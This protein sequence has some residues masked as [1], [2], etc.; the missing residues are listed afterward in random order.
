MIK[1][2]P[3]TCWIAIAALF[4]ALSFSCAN[5]ATPNGGPYD[6]EPPR[7][8]S[9]TPIPNQLTYKGKRV[10]ILFDE[11]IKLDNPLEN[12]IVTPPQKEQPPIRANGRRV[13]VELEDSLRENTTYTIDFTNSISDNNEGNIFQ[14]FSFAFSTGETIDS[15]AV[16]GTVLNAEN[17]EPMPGITIGIHT[18]LADSAFLTTPFIRTSRTNDR[19]EFT[20]RNMAAG[21]YR[22][23]ALND[24]MRSYMHDQPGQEIA[25]ADS[26]IVP[27]FEFA[28]RQDTTW[29]DTLTIDTIQTVHYTRFMPD[30]IVLRLFKEKFDRQY[31]LRP[32]RPTAQMLVI[33]FNAPLDTLPEL[34]PVN[35]KPQMDSAWYFVQRLEENR[36]A[37]VWLIDSTV[38]K[39]DTLRLAMTYPESDSLNI[40]RPRTDT[41]QFLAPRQ[42]EERRRRGKEGEPEPI[43]FLGMSIKASGSINLYDTIAITFT[44]PVLALDS[45]LF[46]L[47][48]MID[49]L[50]QPADF[51]FFPDTA[52]SLNFYLKRDWKYG[53]NYRLTVDSATIYSAYGK[54]NNAFTGDFSIKKEEEYGHLYINTPG[55]TDHA[56]IELLN[57]SDMPVRREPVK[58]GGALFMDLKPDKYYARLIIDRNNNGR[59][60]T[61]DYTAKRQPEEVYYCPKQFNIMQ[62]WEVEENW[63][64]KALPLK[65]QKPMD[66]TKNKPKE[67]T[68]P[69]RDYRNEGRNN[70]SNS[71]SD[72]LRG[73]SF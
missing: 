7:F 9:S 11:L 66:I 44:E 45:S 51:R 68:K 6:E 61:G 58:E 5:M 54:W 35:F 32:E 34:R 17:L 30:D 8:V 46:I 40:L 3:K 49:S 15:L 63:D 48:Q 41:L 42:R 14:N 53:E 64:V 33:R 52:N 69:K 60:D 22:I 10:E 43:E 24:A 1:Y 56:F 31:L 29:I 23:Y 65:R 57:S 59:W 67:I 19:G 18:N 36:A 72:L 27:T 55:I 70:S 21:T 20:I 12:I 16:S 38:W 28:T 39:Q 73:L 4:I 13:T 2:N 25:Y 71:S 62:N 47:E 37:N 26:L 50:W